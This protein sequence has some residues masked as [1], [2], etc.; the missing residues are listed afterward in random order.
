MR[1]ADAVDF[2]LA[3]LRKRRLRTF[4]TGAGVM[5]GIGAL[6]SMIS[7]GKGMQKNVTQA[8][9]S[10]DLF[11][12][13]MVLPGGTAGPSGD[14]DRV[15]PALKQP[16]RPNAALDDA[17]VTAIAK[18]PGVRMAY[19]DI[20]FPAMVGLGQAQEFRLVQI[21]PAA[22]AASSALKVQW[23]RAYASDDE[24]GAVVSRA[25]LRR[26]GLTDPAKAWG[27][28]SGSRRC[29]STWAGWRPS[30]SALSFRGTC[31]R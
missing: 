15:G 25:L 30:T 14:P 28:R 6:V 19:P 4:L 31:P 24:N 3:S 20:G 26:L 27:R 10:S 16:T 18:F 2:A 29:R 12:T 11:T 7:F 17:A 13:I 21:V 5:I 22:V 23:G 8:F 1:F 9:K